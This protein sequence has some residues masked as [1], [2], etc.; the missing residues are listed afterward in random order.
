MILQNLKEQGE[1]PEWL[2]EEG[3]TTLRNGYLLPGETPR[4]MYRRVAKAA[5]DKLP[6][7]P[8]IEHKIFQYIWN[9]WI[10][11][12]T[13]IASNLG[14]DRG[15]PVSC[16]GQRPHDSLDG[17]FKSYHETAM[18]TKNGGGIGK[19]WSDIRGRGASIKGNGTSDGI[20]SWLKIEEAV[21]SGVS[22]GSTRRGAGANYL[23][24]LH[25]DA[26]E[27]IDIRRQTGDPARR[28]LSVNFHH[29]LN[30]PDSFMQDMI[31]GNTRYRNI[32]EKLL[33][34]RVEMGEPYIHFSGNSNKNLPAWY[35]NN[36]LNVKQ[37]QLC[38]EIF[39]P[40]DNQHT[41]TCVLL[42]M[43]AMRFDEWKDTDAVEVAICL[44][45]AV[46]GEF[47][48]KARSVPGLEN[49]VRFTEK[50]RALGLGVLGWHSLL[51]SKMIAFDSFD[52]MQLNA[53]LFRTIKRKA[54][55]ASI[56]LASKYGEVEWTKGHGRRHINLTAVAPTVSNSLI[57]GGVSQGIEPITANIY[58]QK[59][60][61]GTFIRKNPTLQSYLNSLGKDTLEVWEEINKH[62]GSVASL[63]F[64]SD[65]EKEVFATAREINQFAIIRQAAQRQRFIDQG[66][67]VNLFFSMPSDIKDDD[68]RK[69]LG[70]YIHDVHMEAWTSGLKGLYYFRS[71][72]ALKGDS[73]FKES[74]DCKA[75]E[76]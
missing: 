27:F 64:L 42:S 28:C 9:N 65:H 33:K 50:A 6:H 29:A 32:W 74:S 60:A 54:E 76:A 39:L 37:S 31:D 12:S 11:L 20:I 19:D 1:A 18:L 22:Q 8:G 43:N 53:E 75:C 46:A 62:S 51:Q 68:M 7:H 58:S 40:S 59:S 5:G 41:F 16:F 55:A 52:A 23:D 24:I 2:Q 25:P 26:E 17:I 67:S 57:S 4:S 15:L 45:D 14:T 69:K 36:N 66:Q 72:S 44:L 63:S 10:C 34:A 71:E 48:N 61:K 49:A 35:V 47:I 21:L 30:I 13:P 38:N 56:D 3:Y 70:K 73:V